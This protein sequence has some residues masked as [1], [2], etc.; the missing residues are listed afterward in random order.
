M[1]RL[2]PLWLVCCRSEGPFLEVNGEADSQ[3]NPAAR[4]WK[5]PA[6][7]ARAEVFALGNRKPWHEYFEKRR[8]RCHAG[9][10]GLAESRRLLPLR[11]GVRSRD[12]V[13]SLR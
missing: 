4:V 8:G 7:V 6:R 9:R 2:P 5:S 10:A 3:A 12:S 11:Q 13:S 1:C